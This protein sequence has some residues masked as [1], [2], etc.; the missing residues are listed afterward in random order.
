MTDQPKPEK[1]G[2]P[3]GYQPPSYIPGQESGEHPLRAREPAS[4]TGTTA[5]KRR[6]V[7][8]RLPL[9]TSGALGGRG[10]YLRCLGTFGILGDL[11]RGPRALRR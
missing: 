3:E 2:T 6:F 7:E 8:R 11:W 1:D 5:I 9:A 4:R 10:L